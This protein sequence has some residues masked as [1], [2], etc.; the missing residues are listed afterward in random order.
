[1]EQL[2]LDVEKEMLKDYL[3]VLLHVIV[4][5]GFA[6]GT[7]LANLVWAGKRTAAKDAALR[8]QSFA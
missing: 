8:V 3:P 4:A 6:T 2:R 1:M 7:L 5:V